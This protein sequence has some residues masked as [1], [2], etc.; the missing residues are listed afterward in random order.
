MPEGVG[1]G[2][3]G[4]ILV[5]GVQIFLKKM[6]LAVAILNGKYHKV[7][8]ISVFSHREDGAGG[9]GITKRHSHPLS[10]KDPGKAPAYI[11]LSSSYLRSCHNVIADLSNF[12]KLRN[13]WHPNL[14]SIQTPS[15]PLLLPPHVVGHCPNSLHPPFPSHHMLWGTLI[16]RV[17]KLPPPIPPHA[18]WHSNLQSIQTPS[19]PPFPSNHMLWATLIFRVFK[20]PSPLPSPP[21]TCCGAL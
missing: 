20:L 10:Q 6:Q 11:I 1:M 12:W 4:A 9:R 7:M 3:V 18:V 19:T 15:T 16:S 17:S 5:I 2:S 13:F 21:T 14:Q 8:H